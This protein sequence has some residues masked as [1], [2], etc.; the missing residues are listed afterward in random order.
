[1]YNELTNSGCELNT[2]N[3]C[4]TWIGTNYW[5]MN[6]YSLFSMYGTILNAVW[7]IGNPYGRLLNVKPVINLYKSAISQ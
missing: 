3:S 7:Q 2:Q 1:M 4:P 6:G 5:T